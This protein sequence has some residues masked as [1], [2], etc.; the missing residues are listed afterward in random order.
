MEFSRASGILLHPTSLPGAGGIGE[1]GPEAEAFLATLARARQ[2]IWQVLP[3]GPTGENNCP[4]QCDS[5]FAGNPLLVSLERL[6]ADGLLD[7]GDLAA[8]PSFPPELV[9]FS[10]VVPWRTALLAKAHASFRSGR[11]SESLARGLQEF[12]ERERG[13]VD[14]YALYAAIK[15]GGHGAAWVNWPP[16]L[17]R[18]EEGALAEA[19]RVWERSVDRNLFVQFLF[20]EHWGRIRERANGLGISILGDVPIFV[21][22]DCADVWAHP[23]LFDL[24]EDGRPRVVAGVPPDYFSE[25]GQLWG[26]PLYRWGEHAERGFSWWIHRMRAAL[27]LYDRVR[28][29]H[30]RGFESY[31]E[32]PSCEPTAE[33]GRWVEGPKDALFE[34]LRGDLGE[35]PIVAEDLGVITPEVEAL[36]DRWRFPGMRVLQFAFGPDSKNDP[37]APHGHVRNCVVYTGTHDNDTAVGWFSSGENTTEDEAER[38]M[39]RERVLVYLGTDGSEI[40]WDLIRLALTS[41]ADTAILP[42]QD[43]LG[44]GSEARMNIPGRPE[45]HWEWRMAPGAWTED[46]VRRLAGLTESTGRAPAGAPPGASAADGACE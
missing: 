31:W 7:E 26:N 33:D 45:G 35:L 17:V 40:H 38:R 43:V 5:A 18:R 20:S 27:S 29:D 4:Y 2:S 19:R 13:W 34:A 24:G 23:E 6:V 14:D 36:R 10:A 1:L 11:G 46:L 16:E 25:T 39:R 41:V 3:L 44:L 22:A 12:R 30:F 37:H 15:E 9:D 8:A 42:I 32:V 28:I 21:A